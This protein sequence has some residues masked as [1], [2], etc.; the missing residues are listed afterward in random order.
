MA[1]KGVVHQSIRSVVGGTSKDSLSVEPPCPALT[2][3]V[4]SWSGDLPL[5]HIEVIKFLVRETD[6]VRCCGGLCYGPPRF[7]SSF[8]P[9]EIVEVPPLV[10]WMEFHSMPGHCF[11]DS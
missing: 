9:W 10:S 6:F 2:W 11:T 5:S 4:P 7:H 3:E 8:V 1:S